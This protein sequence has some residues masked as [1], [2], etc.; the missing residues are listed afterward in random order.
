MIFVWNERN[1]D[2][3]KN[4][5]KHP[6]DMTA[7]ELAEATRQ[8]EAAGI[9]GVKDGEPP[10]TAMTPTGNREDAE[11]VFRRRL[12]D[13]TLA[14]PLRTVE[15]VGTSRLLSTLTFAQTLALNFC[16]TASA[17]PLYPWKISSLIVSKSN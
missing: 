3:M 9:P 4:A 14:A 15:K 1:I 16:S 6:E 5:A 12:V 13:A 2:P 10:A 17:R 8:F 11:A 7:A